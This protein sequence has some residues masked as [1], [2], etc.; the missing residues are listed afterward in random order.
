MRLRVT[1]IVCAK[2][3]RLR[4][5]PG[6]GHG[7]RSGNA[8]AGTVV[9]NHIGDPFLFDFFSQTQAG[10]QG[11]SRP[12]RYVVLKDEANF[13]ADDLQAL[14]QTISS[15]FQRATRS[16]GLATPAYYADIVASR[17]KLWLNMD[18]EGASTVASGSSGRDQTEEERQNDLEAYQS[19]IQSMMEKLDGLDQQMWWI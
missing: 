11:T 1:Y 17:A 6:N 10:L 7:D 4:L 2:N 9:D 16:V 15:G 14:I 3:H 8:P 12:T 13:S 18:D 5:S 19:K